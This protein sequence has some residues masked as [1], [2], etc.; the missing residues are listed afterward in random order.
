[1]EIDREYQK[2]KNEDDSE[3]NPRLTKLIILFFHFV[4][5]TKTNLK[6]RYK[7]VNNNK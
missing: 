6:A 2:L 3:K 1:M 7:M 5:I 4:T